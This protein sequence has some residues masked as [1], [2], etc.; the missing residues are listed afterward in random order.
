MTQSL[1]AILGGHPFFKGLSKKH[2]KLIAGCAK[3]GRFTAGQQIFLEGESAD[4]FYFIEK[5]A[6]SIELT[7]PNKETTRVLQVGSGEILGWS[8]LAPPFHWH[9]NARA[10]EATKAIVFDAKCLRGK[11]EVD[12]ELGYEIFKRFATVIV[13]RLDATQVQL[14]DLYAK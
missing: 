6:V 7:V 3:N 10:I 5:G 4:K 14:L 9:F 11:C 1:E 2:L 8:W 13:E 12:H